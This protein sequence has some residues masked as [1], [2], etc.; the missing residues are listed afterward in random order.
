[1]GKGWADLYA[2][3][4]Q[5]HGCTAK[6]VHVYDHS[7]QL[8][9]YRGYCAE[10]FP[11]VALEGTKRFNANMLALQKAKAEKL[12]AELIALEAEIAAAEAP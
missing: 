3:G 11:L 8:P 1:M 9:D 5:W 4:C 10:H 6:V 12:R 2:A 7:I